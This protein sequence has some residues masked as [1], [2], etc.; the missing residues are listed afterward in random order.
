MEFRRR[1]GPKNMNVSPDVLAS[2][3]TEFGGDKGTDLFARQKELLDE[4]KAAFETQTVMIIGH[5]RSLRTLLTT[6]GHGRKVAP[7]GDFLSFSY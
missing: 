6:L 5:G 7:Q 4:L 3:F 2:D 1:C